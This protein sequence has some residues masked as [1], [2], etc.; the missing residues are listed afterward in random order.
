[1]APAAFHDLEDSLLT[2][3][4]LDPVKVSELLERARREIDD[5]LLPSCQ[6]ALAR[7]GEV[8]WTV[9]LGQ[10]TPDSRYVIFSC[11]KALTAGAVWLLLG[12]GA[13]TRDLRVAEVIPEFATNGKD[14]V[15]VEQLLTHTSGFPYA[16]LG[17]PAWA[18][19]DARLEAYAKWRLNW[20]PGTR[21]EYHPTSAHW[22]LG[23]LVE[24]VTGTGLGEYL[25]TRIFD[26]LGL[27][28]VRLGV[29]VDQQADVQP[30]VRT[31]DPPSSAELE[32]AL[33]IP[34]IT[35]DDLLGEVTP[36][37]LMEF[38]DPITRST[39]VPG[40]GGVSTA[41]DLALYYQALLHNPGGLWD[42]DVLRVGTSDVLCNLPDRLRGGA[43]MRTLGLIAA[44]DD[45]EAATRGMGFT[46]S[47]QAFGHNGAGGQIAFA[48]PATGLSFVYLTNG[49]DAHLIREWKRTAG[50]ASRA[51][52]CAA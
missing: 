6:L 35:L 43:S 39:G 38:N 24:R 7:D 32:A 25:T 27:S 48:D 15:T 30:L 22:I 10:S 23:E 14:V 46:V 17:A 3:A 16:P 45:G 19:P 42:P 37:A 52:V 50:L 18:D 5:G 33:G 2:D 13:I 49:L 34:D 1:M 21:F 28:A 47:N 20:E 41:A 11:T 9:T 44:G 4:G 29:P 26:P 40:G 31:G 36:A 12:E 51:A 8:A